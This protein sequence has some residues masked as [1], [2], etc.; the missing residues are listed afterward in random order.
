MKTSDKIQ[1]AFETETLGNLGMKWRETYST[2][3]YL[4]EKSQ[5]HYRSIPT[6]D[7]CS[8]QLHSLMA[9]FQSCT[10]SHRY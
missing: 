7:R 2:Q 4:L 10:C 9:T 1:D 5:K 8:S 3:S 6:K